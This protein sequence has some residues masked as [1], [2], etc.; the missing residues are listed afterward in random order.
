MMLAPLDV[1]IVMFGGM[2]VSREAHCWAPR[3]EPQQVGAVRCIDG[4]SFGVE[5]RAQRDVHADH[6]QF[7]LRRVF[8]E[9]RHEGKLTLSDLALVF[10]ATT[11][12]ARIGSQIRY[13]IKHD[14]QRIAVVEGIMRRPKD[15]LESLAR[16]VPIKGLEIEIVI[17]ADVPPWDAD[18]A[19]DAIVATIHCEIIEQDVASRNAERRAGADEW[20]HG[21]VA[22]EIELRLAL[23]LWV[24]EEDHIVL[25]RL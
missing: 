22:D 3:N 11:G 13:V 20:D 18:L 19:N 14:K 9:V 5:I 25:G 21:V 15:P 2:S 1:Q 17:A 8:E 7:V 4:G 23:R 12:S 10:A 6:D 16:I 24:G